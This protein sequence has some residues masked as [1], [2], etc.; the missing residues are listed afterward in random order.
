MFNL[1][2]YTFRKDKNPRHPET[3]SIRSAGIFYKTKNAVKKSRM[4]N[5]VREQDGQEREELEINRSQ[6]TQKNQNQHIRFDEVS[7][8]EN[9]QQAVIK[10]RE[11]E[12]PFNYML[13]SDDHDSD[14]YCTAD[15]DTFSN[16]VNA[17]SPPEGHETTPG[18]NSLQSEMKC[19]PLEANNREPSIPF[20]RDNVR[21]RHRRK[22][23]AVKRLPPKPLPEELRSCPELEKY[24][25]QRFR[26]FS[27]FDEGIQLDRESWFSVT[28]EAIAKHISER[29]QCDLIV[30]AFC[31]GGGN[32]IQVA[33]IIR[34][35]I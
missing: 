10:A 26:L 24:W 25:K 33:T 14:A 9:E 12:T 4:L 31:G 1:L 32:T 34:S 17:K 2:G 5:I 7:E 21:S 8:N 15:E 6:T 29:C 18:E 28:P 27:K 20:R 16:E 35:I 3:P 23:K 19:I 11:Q 13:D 30:D 22:R